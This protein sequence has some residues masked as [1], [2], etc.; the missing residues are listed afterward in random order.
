MSTRRIATLTV[1]A[2]LAGCTTEGPNEDAAALPGELR[3]DVERAIPAPS[4]EARSELRAGGVDFALSLYEHASSN[5]GNVVLSPHSVSSAFAMLR[6]GARGESATEIDTVFGYPEGD[7]LYEAANELDR[8]LSSRR[9]DK[10]ALDVANAAFLQTGYDVA[11]SYLDVLGRSFGAGIGTLDFHQPQAAADAINEWVSGRTNDLIPELVTSSDVAMARLVLVN[12]VYFKGAWKDPFEARA[13]LP[14]DFTRRDGSVVQ[15][16]LMNDS[17]EM[18]YYDGSDFRAG[19]LAY[20][21]DQLAMLVILPDDAAGIDELEA[22]LD[23]GLLAD[24]DGS[25]EDRDDVLVAMPRFKFESSFELRGAL[26][27]MGMPHV[28]GTD[29]D[30]SGIPASGS[31]E[32]SVTGVIHKATIEVTEEGT[33]AAAATGI[34]LAGSA[35]GPMVEPPSLQLDH[36]FLFAIRD[37][38]TGAVLF[39]GRVDDPS[40]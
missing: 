17:R 27:D 37:T 15:T 26:S 23:A 39:L 29:A 35:P 24:I 11:P 20:M 1:L 9:T 13:T 7:M 30:L 21:G 36:P 22:R 34:I 10:V 5:E 8:T 28:F 14:G 31:R 40:L 16:P 4:A 2:A 18:P 3:S 38:G 12:A 6:A 19:E 25:L 33:E 32:L